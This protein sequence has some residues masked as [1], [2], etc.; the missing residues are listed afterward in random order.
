MYMVVLAWEG[1]VFN[2]RYM[3]EVMRDPELTPG[4]QE[5]KSIC[6]EILSQ[7][8]TGYMMTYWDISTNVDPHR[9][10]DKVKATAAGQLLFLEGEP[11]SAPQPN[12]H[13]PDLQ[14]YATRAALKWVSLRAWG[15]EY[16]KVR[17]DP[18]GPSSPPYD[19]LTFPGETDWSRQLDISLGYANDVQTA[20][21]TVT[22]HTS[23]LR[24][25]QTPSL[26]RDVHAMAY[27]ETGYEGHNQKFLEQVTDEDVLAFTGI[28]RYILQNRKQQD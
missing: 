10:L 16:E 28:C 20:H 1:N 8:P 21:V 13:W 18:D 15:W 7:K 22:S 2:H 14:L 26:S 25:G 27:A 3:S 23:S 24:A 5:V 17:T 9:V 6:D 4:Q 11:L 19:I 12:E